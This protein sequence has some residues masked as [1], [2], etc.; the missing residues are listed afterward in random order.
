MRSSIGVLSLLFL[1]CIGASPASITF[2]KDYV[3]FTTLDY[4][5]RP[6]ANGNVLV[7]GEAST[8]SAFDQLFQYLHS[9]PDVGG[10]VEYSN[11]SIELAPGEFFR[12]VLVPT[13]GERH[14]D[15]SDFGGPII[16]PSTIWI[17]GGTPFAGNV[18]P[19]SGL[20]ELYAFQVH[21]SP[22]P[23]PE[24]GEFAMLAVGLAALGFLKRNRPSQT[25]E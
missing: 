19:L 3:P 10:P 23:V 4:V 15:F 5:S 25:T 11:S 16:D 24:P 14:G 6:D 9:L 13:T 22:A 12:R 17:F 8:V 21:L 18:I 20:F 2:P 7:V 1:S